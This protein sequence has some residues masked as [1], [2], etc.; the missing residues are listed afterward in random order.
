MYKPLC[1]FR[2]MEQQLHIILL[3]AVFYFS[4]LEHCFFDKKTTKLIDGVPAPTFCLQRAII[5]PES[6]SRSHQTHESHPYLRLLSVA[7]GRNYFWINNKQTSVC[8]S[9]FDGGKERKI[10]AIDNFQKKFRV[11]AFTE[12]KAIFILCKIG[13]SPGTFEDL[14]IYFG[15]CRQGLERLQWKIGNRKQWN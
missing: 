12:T 14:Y 13:T 6:Q 8:I 9:E 11:R 10:C 4:I 15:Q 2:D 3:N 5:I 7:D 1:W